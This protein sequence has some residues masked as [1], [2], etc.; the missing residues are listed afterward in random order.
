MGCFTKQVAG[1]HY[2]DGSPLHGYTTIARCHVSTDIVVQRPN[3][4]TIFPESITSLPHRFIPVVII[5]GCD[6][7]SAFSEDEILIVLTVLLR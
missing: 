6:G 7:I 3:N 1:H 4:S 5:E 2:L